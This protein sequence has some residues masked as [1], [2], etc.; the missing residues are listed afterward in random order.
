M[1]DSYTEILLPFRSDP[2]LLEQYTN[3]SG[4]IR[5]GKLLEHL[6]SLAG[7]IA[8]KHVLGPAVEKV[9][10][11]TERGFYIVTASVDRMDMLAPLTPV[12]DLRLS[13]QVICVGKSSIE[14]AVKMEALDSGAEQDQTLMLGRFSMVC[15]DAFTHRAYAVNPLDAGTP[16][17]AALRA[18]GQAH[19]RRRQTR[20]QRSLALVPPSSAEARV[21][22][23]FSLAHANEPLDRASVWMGETRLERTMLMFPQ[24]R[25]VH[26]KI[27]GGY[28]MRLAYE[29]GFT[30]ARLFT[31]QPV[32]FVSLDNIAFARPVPIGSILRLTS[33]VLHTDSTP[34]HPSVVHVRVKAEVV[35]VETGSEQQTNDFRFTWG[36]DASAPQR[37]VVPRTYREAM[38]WLEGRRALEIGAAIQGLRA[39]QR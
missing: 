37:R 8:Y 15:R 13:G 12:R 33:G 34:Q 38:L 14:V 4:G 11:I 23:A 3:A 32:R 17:E 9:G 29:L 24:E 35:D 30:T 5:T 10:K 6:D 36:S 39:S 22:H 21:L 19:R 25:N 1:H 26:Q 31:R 18:I 27:F 28:L 7:S 16:E 2:E 20:A